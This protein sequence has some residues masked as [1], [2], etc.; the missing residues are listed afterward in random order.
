MVDELT[1]RG[2]TDIYGAINKGLEMV[3][4]RH[5]KTRNP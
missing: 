3:A 5:I 4:K 2:S 1:A